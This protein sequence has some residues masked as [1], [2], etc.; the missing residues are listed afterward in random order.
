MENLERQKSP[1]GWRDLVGFESV[2]GNLVI[3]CCCWPSDIGTLQSLCVANERKREVDL[4]SID[5]TSKD[6][7]NCLGDGFNKRVVGV[8][9]V[10]KVD[11]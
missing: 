6:I 11:P 10:S 8:I 4:E 9:E 7:L 1:E 2:V 3:G 5:L